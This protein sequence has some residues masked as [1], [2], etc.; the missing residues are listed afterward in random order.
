MFVEES[1]I[2]GPH[3]FHSD[4]FI[5]YIPPHPETQPETN[6]EIDSET[7]HGTDLSNHGTLLAITYPTK[8]AITYPRENSSL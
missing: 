8:L 7:N 1:I 3:E 5:P 2:L 4:E 6:S